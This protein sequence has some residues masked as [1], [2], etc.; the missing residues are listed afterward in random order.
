LA[1]VQAPPGR[2]SSKSPDGVAVNRGWDAKIGIPFNGKAFKRWRGA[3]ID[4]PQEK[5]AGAVDTHR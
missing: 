1:A 2:N 4:L 3:Q 5:T